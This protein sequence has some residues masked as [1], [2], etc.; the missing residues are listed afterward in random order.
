MSEAAEVLKEVPEV[1]VEDN[2]Q[3]QGATAQEKEVAALKSEAAANR[4]KAK[5]LQE[6]LDKI[7]TDQAAK[8]EETAIKNGE[9]EKIVEAQ[10]GVIEKLTGENETTTAALQTYLDGE[11]DG[12]SDDMKALIPEGSIARKLVWITKAREA[13]LFKARKIANGVMDSG[14]EKDDSGVFSEEIKKATTQ[15]EL[16]AVL[17]KYGRA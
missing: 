12:V 6:K 16:D 1:K 10:K 5:E 17:T 4:V 9:A 14:E 11:L 13:G 3:S 7:N 15:Q 2:S 8:E